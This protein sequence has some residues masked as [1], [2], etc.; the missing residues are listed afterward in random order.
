MHHIDL[1]AERSV[2]DFEAGRKTGPGEE[3]PPNFADLDA[4]EERVMAFIQ[5]WNAIA[6][7]FNWTTKSFEK[8]LAKIDDA[9]KEAA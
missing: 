2:A 9:L 6:H 8:T 7:P 5:E 4:L 1:L 3:L